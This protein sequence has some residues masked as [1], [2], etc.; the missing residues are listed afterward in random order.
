MCI[1]EGL[2]L[3]PERCFLHTSQIGPAAGA[4]AMHKR[5][6]AAGN[7]LSAAHAS[8]IIAIVAIT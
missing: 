4:I 7:N 3:G 5:S 6:D 2:F 1:C 8:A